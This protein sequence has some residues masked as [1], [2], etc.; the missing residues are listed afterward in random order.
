MVKKKASKRAASKA[1]GAPEQADPDAALARVLSQQLMIWAHGLAAKGDRY[2]CP[3]PNGTVRDAA[4]V[5]AEVRRVAREWLGTHDPRPNVEDGKIRDHVLAKLK[6][7]AGRKGP[8]DGMADAAIATVRLGHP[9]VAAR[10]TQHREL[11]IEI[12]TSYRS[13]PGGRGRRVVRGRPDMI[14]DLCEAMGWPANTEAIRSA[15]RRRKTS[16]RPKH[17]TH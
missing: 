1:D 9:D 2:R 13:K 15:R 7:Y 10:L 12:M 17:V 8:V 16:P 11:V 3:G 14:S 4:D 5:R 6:W